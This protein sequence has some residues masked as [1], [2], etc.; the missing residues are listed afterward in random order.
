MFAR[1]LKFGDYASRLSSSYWTALMATMYSCKF[2]HDGASLHQTLSLHLMTPLRLTPE[3]HR[4][5]GGCIQSAISEVFGV[6]PQLYPESTCDACGGSRTTNGLILRPPRLLVVEVSDDE[7][8]IFDNWRFPLWLDIPY[9]SYRYHLIGRVLKPTPDHFSAISRLPGLD[10]ILSHDG[11]R[12]RGFV[13][14]DFP[15]DMDAAFGCGAAPSRD[16]V[17]VLEAGAKAQESIYRGR[18]EILEALFQFKLSENP[19]LESIWPLVTLG[20]YPKILEENRDDQPSRRTYQFAHSDD[21]DTFRALPKPDGPSDQRPQ[22]LDSDI[23][24]GSGENS[25]SENSDTNLHTKAVK[26]DQELADPSSPRCDAATDLDVEAMELEMIESFGAWHGDPILDDSLLDAIQADS[27]NALMEDQAMRRD[28]NLTFA[29]EQIALAKTHGICE[30]TANF[31]FFLASYII[32]VRFV[33]E[34]FICPYCQEAFE[35]WTEAMRNILIRALIFRPESVSRT[36]DGV[37]LI[38][39][40]PKK[41]NIQVSFRFCELHQE[42]TKLGRPLAVDFAALPARIQSLK[43]TI[44]RLLENPDSY[45]FIAQIRNIL[46]PELKRTRRNAR[47]KRNGARIEAARTAKFSLTPAIEVQT[48]FAPVG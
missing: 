47:T 30:Y 44:E 23:K 7:T 16:A 29:A 15:S 12:R 36:A 19:N 28:E 41:E 37:W 4:K 10:F 33:V 45:P 34:Q 11:L 32:I 39:S 6:T 5:H 42:I 17:Y 13:E 27:L 24:F 43:P 1:K 31:P 35:H 9:S 21:A 14:A 3:Q 20:G 40:T 46:D 38:D 18:T 2:Q 8:M 26:I 25:S 22:E 48:D